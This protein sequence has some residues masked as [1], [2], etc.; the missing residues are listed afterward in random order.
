MALENQAANA[1]LRI[2]GQK[3][4]VIRIS[5]VN[6]HS[7]YIVHVNCWL[8]STGKKWRK[9]QTSHLGSVI[10]SNGH[11]EQ[12]SAVLQWLRPTGSS[13]SLTLQTELQ[14]LATIV[15]PTATYVYETWMMA[16]TIA[17]KLDVYHLHCL[18]R[19]IK[20][21]YWDHVTNMEV[22]HHAYT[23]PL[24]VTVTEHCFARHILHLLTIGI[25]KM[26]IS[27]Q[28]AQDKWMPKYHLAKNFYGRSA[29]SRHSMAQGWSHNRRSK[30]MENAFHPMCQTT[31]VELR[32][33]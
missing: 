21:I 12:T 19:I 17:R 1:G 28:S 33:R 25:F 22:C 31:P 9:L 3:T 8:Q 20:I 29:S 6:L 5:Y 14:L 26:T 13:P 18:R 30:P 16:K 24:S 7:T 32:L 10:S 15:V 4:K 2:D 27:L 23:Q 11:A